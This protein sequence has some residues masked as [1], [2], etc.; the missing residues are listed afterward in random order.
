[1][2][3]LG[4]NTFVI[5]GIPESAMNKNI[6]ELLEKILDNYKKNL[7]DLDQDNKSNLAK[8][9]AANLA[10][11]SSSSMAM[12]EMEGLISSLFSSSV[13]ETSPAGKRIISM[14]SQEEIEKLFK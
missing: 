13:P 4:K 3:D 9:M 2:N 6:R 7:L 5:T 14:I 8:A 10:V 11:K 12:E 1:M